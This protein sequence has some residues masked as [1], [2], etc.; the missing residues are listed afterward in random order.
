MNCITSVHAHGIRGRALQ[1]CS[2]WNRANL[3]GERLVDVALHVEGEGYQ[4]T[5][6]KII[7]CKEALP[8]L[9]HRL[10]QG[11]QGEVSARQ[12]FTEH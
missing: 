9:Q 8:V 11:R 3:V 6:T 1:F 10:W 5:D 4:S 7:A 12:V 2:E